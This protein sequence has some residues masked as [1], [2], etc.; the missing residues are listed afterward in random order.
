MVTLSEESSHTIFLALGSNLGDRMDNLRA[1]VRLMPPKV[2]ITSTSR[3]YET[4]P[5]GYLE[6]PPFL[7]QVVRGITTLEP[8][9]LL[10][11]IK[12]LEIKMG[13]QPT[14]RYGPRLIDIDILF[15]DDLIRENRNLTVPHPR[16]HERAFVLVPLADLAPDYRHPVIGMS[17]QQLL[18]QVDARQIRLFQPKN[19]LQDKAG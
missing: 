1:A 9:A 14:V 6:Q 4:P 18:S 19:T 15:Y 16:L 8:E 13:R 2:Q 17:I 12:Q 3:I 11:Y 10:K 5:W 7:N